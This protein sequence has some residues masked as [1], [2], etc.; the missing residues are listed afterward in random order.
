[1]KNAKVK[2]RAIFGK[3]QIACITDKGLIALALE[4]GKILAKSGKYTVRVSFKPDT[5]SIFSPGVE[6]ADEE[7]RPND[8]VVVVHKDEVVGV[9]R[10]LLSGKEMTRAKIGLAVKLRHRL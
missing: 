8:E 10:A 4:G 9:G 5:N 7:I 2:G 3:K 6:E 1:M